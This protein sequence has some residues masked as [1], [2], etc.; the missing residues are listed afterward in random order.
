MV[1]GWSIYG[2]SDNL[3]DDGI[4]HKYFP[5]MSPLDGTTKDASVSIE[6]FRTETTKSTHGKL[7][8]WGVVTM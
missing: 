3:E 5:G 6:G 8:L 4:N 7:V 1:R 2:G